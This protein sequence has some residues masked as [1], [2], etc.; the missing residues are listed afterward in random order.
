MYAH[1]NHQ[2]YVQKI[3]LKK[4]KQKQKQFEKSKGFSHALI[5]KNQYNKTNKR[6]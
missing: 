4:Y 3:F 6:K 5:K 1:I 2:L